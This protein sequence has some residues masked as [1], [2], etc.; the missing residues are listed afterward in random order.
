MTVRRTVAVSDQVELPR[1]YLSWFSPPVFKPGDAECDIAAHILG[2]GKSSRLYKKLVYERQIAQDVS[3]WNQG[4][5]LGSVFAVQAT[6]KPGVKLEELEKAINEEIAYFRQNGPTKEEVEGARNMLEMRIV[7]GLETMGGFGGVA[8]RLNLYNY[9][10]ADPGYLPKDLARYENATMAG[11]QKIA[12]QYLTDNSCV[13]VKGLPGKK[14]IED[15]PRAVDADKNEVTVLDAGSP[16]EPW[17]TAAPTPAAAPRLVLPVPTSFQ[18]ANGLTVYLMERHNLPIVA[19]DLFVLG[20][21]SAN[22][23]DKPGL[24]SFTADMLDEGTSGRSTM[25]IAGDLDRIG[26]ALHTASGSDAAWARD[27]RFDEDR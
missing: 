13:V 8:D 9:F 18:L 22:P 4:L 5:M 3:V 20:G 11:V 23:V 10:L 15:V 6:A 19:A 27:S 17:R 26:S 16:D 7:H 1:L 12:N 2:G 14:V 24:S 25:A 21:S